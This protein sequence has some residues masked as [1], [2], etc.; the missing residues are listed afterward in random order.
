MLRPERIADAEALKALDTVVPTDPA[1][2][3]LIETWLRE[4]AVV[5]AEVYGRAVGYGV[6]SHGFFR[7]SEAEMLMVAAE[8]RGRGIGGQL[9]A[10]L[11]RRCDTPKFFV[12]TNASNRSMQRL[13]LRAGY[14]VCGC[15]G[16]L[17]P[18]D[19]EVVFVKK[20]GEN[21]P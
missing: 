19:P 13:L 2:A 15:I 20:C 10:A 5:V 18:G 16:E 8:H 1:R 21:V 3:L 9:L 11:E 17:D 14:T 7:Q 4:E 12:T 6:L